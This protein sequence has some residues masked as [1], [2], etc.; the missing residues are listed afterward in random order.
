MGITNAQLR[1]IFTTA[2]SIGMD[3]DELHCMVHGLTGCESIRQL[4]TRQGARIIDR[5]EVLAGSKH[6]VAGRATSAQQR[7][8]L[9]LAHEMGWSG[10][11]SRLRGFLEKKAHVSDVRFLNIDTARW[12]IEAMKKMQEGGRAERRQTLERMDE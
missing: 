12:I 8:I 6:D 3:N 9:A 11:P 4:N 10:D 1:K 7:K 2:R 5:L